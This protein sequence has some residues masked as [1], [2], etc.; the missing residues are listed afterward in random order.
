MRKLRYFALY[1]CGAFS[2]S[3]TVQAEVGFSY[4]GNTFI[5]Y[6]NCIGIYSDAFLVPQEKGWFFSME[7]AP[8]QSHVLNIVQAKEAQELFQALGFRKVYEDKPLWEKIGCV[9]YFRGDLPVAL[10]RMATKTKDSYGIGFVIRGLPAGAWVA[11]GPGK[12]TPMDAKDNP[13]V[14]VVR[15]QLTEACYAPDSAIR[16]RQFPVRNDRSI[17]QLDIGKA[18]KMSS[19]KKRQYIEEEMRRVESVYAQQAWPEQKRR[20][21]EKL[22][23]K[24]FVESVEICRFFLDEGRVLKTEKISRSSGVEERVDTPTDLNTDNWWDTTDTAI[25]FISLNEGKDWDALFVDVG[26]EGI[27]YRIVRLNGTSVLYDRSLY[28]FH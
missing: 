6:N 12:S 2:I 23:S 25:G 1:L 19:E 26:F 14:E 21:L 7:Q 3:M 20:T 27:H 16:K 9:H 17:I 15:H 4:Y 18:K 13:F 11:E 8:A 5:S 28:T 22:E 24:D 10:A